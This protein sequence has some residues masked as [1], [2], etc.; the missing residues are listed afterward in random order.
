MISNGMKKQRTTALLIIFLVFFAGLI[1]SPAQFNRGINLLN[2]FLPFSISEVRE[3]DFQLGLDLQGGAHLLYQADLTGVS[4][5]EVDQR[6]DGVRSLIER[7]IDYFGISESVVQVKGDRLIVELPG[8]HDLEEAI[9]TIGGTPF[10]DFREMSDETQEMRVTKMRE[11]SEAL[12]KEFEEITF[13]DILRLQEEEGMEG[14]GI[15]FESPYKTTELT[16]RHLKDAR[17]VFDQVTGKPSISLEFDREG[18]LILEAVT[19]RNVG[20]PLA[21]FLDGEILQEATVSEKITGGKAQIT[22]DFTVEEATSLA[23]DLNIGALPVP[24]E[25]ISQQSIGPSLGE[26]SIN[27]S[28]RAGLWG[29]AI[30]SLFMILI[31]RLP[32]FISVISLFIYGMILLALFKLIPVTLTLSGIAGFILSIGM[33]IDA[34]ILIFS[35]MREELRSGKGFKE[36]VEEGLRR[37]WP[38][39][40]DGNFTT[41]VAAM[42]FFFIATSFVR[43][44][45]VTLILGIFVSVFSAMVITRFLLLLL[46]EKSSEKVKKLWI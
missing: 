40:R 32:G 37:A 26:E 42:V 36:S 3:R 38:S 43:G 30:I 1:L 13:E 10:L 8:V 21:T 41:L 11:V 16:G 24:I 44:F 14:L 28:V 12:E 15:I 29:F 9:D 45:A 39:I 31:Y 7:R 34:N 27:L 19:G 17:V 4:E 25:L 22:G 18:S 46:A 2:S 35:R 6:M 5:G 33:A 20:R 23:R